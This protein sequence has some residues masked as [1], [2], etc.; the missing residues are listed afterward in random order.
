MSLRP[1]RERLEAVWRQKLHAAQEA[2][3]IASA[4]TLQVR[5]ELPSMSPTDGNFALRNALKQEHR[6]LDAYTSVLETFTRLILYGEKPDD[7]AT[8]TLPSG[9]RQT[10]FVTDADIQQWVQ[11]RHGFIPHPS[12]IAHCR[13]LYSGAPPERRPPW[14]KCPRDKRRAIREAF[15]ALGVLPK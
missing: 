13:A 7:S 1:Q 6:A 10:S 12:W 5:A 14:L 2:Y 3:R 4:K 11:E 8:I 9:A 15:V